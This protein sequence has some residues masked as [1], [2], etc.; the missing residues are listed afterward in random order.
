M[1][2]SADRERLLAAIETELA[3]LEALCGRLEAALMRRRWQ[4]LE[5]AMADSRRVTHALQNAMDDA[6][7]VRDRAFDEKIF[8][9]IRYVYAVRENQMARLRQFQDSVRERLQMFV[10][11]KSAMRSMASPQRRASKL[12]SLDQLS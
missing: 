11:W 2:P 12:A 6:S 4:E 8:G 7:D 5:T 10:K 9:R 3:E 1:L